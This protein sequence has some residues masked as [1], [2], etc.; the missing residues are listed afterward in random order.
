MRADLGIE[1][2]LCRED[3]ADPQADAFTQNR[4]RAGGCKCPSTNDL[5]GECFIGGL[6][7]SL[8]IKFGGMFFF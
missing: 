1:Y 4:L 2:L 3:E 6:F 5:Q 7:I 8:K